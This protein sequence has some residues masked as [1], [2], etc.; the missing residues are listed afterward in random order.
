V[1]KVKVR[2]EEDCPE[3]HGTGEVLASMG[4]FARL[5]PLRWITSP[6]CG[7]TGTVHSVYEVDETDLEVKAD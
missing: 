2:I 4:F 5:P 1:A 3:C 7:G 6:E